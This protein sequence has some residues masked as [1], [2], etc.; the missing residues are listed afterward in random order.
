MLEF[1]EVVAAP[2]YLEFV[3]GT[4]VSCYL[5]CSWVASRDGVFE[6]SGSGSWFMGLVL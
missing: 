6:G 1:L 2:M 5:S 3:M 4:A